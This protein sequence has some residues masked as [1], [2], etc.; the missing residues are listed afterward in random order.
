VEELF[1]SQGNILEDETCVQLVGT[2]KTQINEVIEKQNNTEQTEVTIDRSRQSYDS[3]AAHASALYCSVTKLEAV[4]P[5]YQFSLSWFT[6]L[7]K[8][9]IDS[10][11]RVEDVTRRLQ[12]LAQQFNI[13]LYRSVSTSLFEKV[14]NNAFTHTHMNDN[15]YFTG[16]TVICCA[17][18]HGN[19]CTAFRYRGVEIFVTPSHTFRSGMHQSSCLAA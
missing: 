14:S 2:A 11:E 4:N 5:M 16:Q 19:E 6:D 3:I 13:A 18:G 8:S 10:T 7:F 12:D 15:K 1:L 9:V 17:A